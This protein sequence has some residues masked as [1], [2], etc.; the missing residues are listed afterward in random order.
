M[1]K[2]QIKQ[3]VTQAA[4]ELNINL[5]VA[6]AVYYQYWNWV[7]DTLSSYPLLNTL[8]EEECSKLRLSFNIPEFGKFYTNHS[9]AV[10]VEKFVE[11][12]YGNKYKKDKT[13]V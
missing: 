1:L 2:S 9:L 4:R 11:K 12:R 10:K 13:S 3:I 7:N 5:Q 8:S 6:H